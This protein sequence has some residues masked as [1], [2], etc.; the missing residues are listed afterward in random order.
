MPNPHGY[1]VLK[2]TTA[3]V[4]VAGEA[5]ESGVDGEI[6][7]RPVMFLQGTL[8]LD[9]E[10][11]YRFPWSQV[12]TS[13]LGVWMF[14]PDGLPV[15]VSPGDGALPGMV[16]PPYPWVLNDGYAADVYEAFPGAV[17]E[18]TRRLVNKADL[19]VEL[20]GDRDDSVATDG[21]V[22]LRVDRV[23]RGSGVGENEDI[24]FLVKNPSVLHR[25]KTTSGSVWTLRNEN[26][27]W[28]T[29]PTWL[30]EGWNCWSLPSMTVSEMFPDIY[31]NR[32]CR[33]ATGE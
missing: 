20:V 8:D 27:S 7:L 10:G 29:E 3:D 5:V 11:L 33:E 23:L 13:E 19:V 4:V 15:G 16:L 31:A 9:D 30:A 22:T 26:G 1:Y 17:A 25:V 32:S 28:V 6:A 2:L 12:Q 24:T 14:G 18:E 21:R